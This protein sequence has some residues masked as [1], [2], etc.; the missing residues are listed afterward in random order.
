M[1]ATRTLKFMSAA[2][3]QINRS[4][5][6]SNKQK[7]SYSDDVSRKRQHDHRLIDGWFHKNLEIHVSSKTEETSIQGN[8]N[9]HYSNYAIN[10]SVIIGS[11]MIASTKTLQFISVTF[12]YKLTLNIVVQT[13]ELFI[14]TSFVTM[15]CNNVETSL[16]SLL[17]QLTN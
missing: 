7:L 9:F 4:I 11:M 17:I 16:S 6:H 10:I 15:F 8:R 1:V 13:S 5:Q 2:V 14:A 3:Y 12:S